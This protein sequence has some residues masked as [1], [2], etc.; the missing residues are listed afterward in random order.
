[1]G[2]VTVATIDTEIVLEILILV[3]FQSL[4]VDLLCECY[5]T[6]GNFSLLLMRWATLAWFYACYVAT[7]SRYYI[8]DRLNLT[9]QRADEQKQLL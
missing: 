3:V 9:P 8:R 4:L 7:T 2:D 5:A 1:M 6:R